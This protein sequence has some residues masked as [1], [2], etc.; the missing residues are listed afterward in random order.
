MVSMFS[1]HFFNWTKQLEDQGHDIYWIDVYDANIYVE[2][3]DFVHQIVGWRNRIKYPGRY[4]IKEKFPFLYNFIN[5][6]NQRKLV[7]VFEKKLKAIQ[8][9]IVQTFEM[10]S[11]SIPV[12]EVM[13]KY[14]KIPWVYSI[15]GN[16]LFYF[17]KEKKDEEKMRRVL[18][19]VNYLFADCK[20][21]LI[22][23]EKLGY[24]NNFLGVYPTG[25]GYEF[26]RYGL[27]IKHPEK[28]NIILIKGYQHT[29]GRCNVILEAIGKLR[30]FLNDYNVVV[31]GA[32]Q[33]VIE[34]AKKERLLEWKNFSI[35]QQVSHERVLELMGNA[36]IYI[37]NSVSD[38]MPNTLLEA[39]IMVIGRA[40]V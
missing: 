11:S 7:D 13:D 17:Q 22:L 4:K 3:I 40:H 2:K 15:W 25:G 19:R 1:S 32:N 36:R 34:F 28:R 23:A 5:K 18:T 6:F 12:L 30:A 37:G 27:Y 8:P 39:I 14:P 33:E 16:D 38:G 21:D 9:D 10:F 29:F 24:K 20:R 26:T 35:Y 31:F